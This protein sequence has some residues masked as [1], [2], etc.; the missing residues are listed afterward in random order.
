MPRACRTRGI[1]FAFCP[2]TDV[3]LTLVSTPEPAEYLACVYLLRMAHLEDA[4]LDKYVHASRIDF[5][6][7]LADRMW[8]S[9]ED[10]VIRAAQSIWSGRQECGVGEACQPRLDDAHFR[11]ILEAMAMRRGMQIQ[12]VP[13]T[14]EKS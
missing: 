1:T 9:T 5:K 2:P 12:F 3:R 6:G 8:S 13:T 11:T 7:L 10:I 14:D 4:V